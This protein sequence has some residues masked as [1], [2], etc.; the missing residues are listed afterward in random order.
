[1]RTRTLIV[2][3]VIVMLAGLAIIQGEADPQG[4]ASPQPTFRIGTFKRTELLVAYY[5]S[6]THG[7]VMK[8]LERERDRARSAG[9]EEK[10]EKLEAQGSA[11]QEYAHKQLAG[12]APLQNVLE[13]LQDAFPAIAKEAGVML[14]VEQPL[15]RDPS[16]QETDITPWLVK[17]FESARTK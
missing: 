8:E 4:P 10:A 15:Y 7:N 13:H 14:I 6:T 17:R 2:C 3:G 16:V 12:E 11:S 5:G 9:D 1:M